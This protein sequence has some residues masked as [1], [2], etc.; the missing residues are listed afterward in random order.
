MLEKLQRSSK[1]MMEYGHYNVMDN[2]IFTTLDGDLPKFVLFLNG[3]I[4]VYR[5]EINKFEKWL[6]LF[7]S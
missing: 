6:D 2:E 4:I 7:F 5:D 1:G 3:K